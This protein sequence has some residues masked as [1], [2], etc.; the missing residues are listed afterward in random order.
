[1][2]IVYKWL[3]PALIILL[4]IVMV[5]MMM[6]NREQSDDLKAEARWKHTRKRIDLRT[7]AG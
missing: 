2:K 1:M 7:A 5:G 3:Y 6:N 4:L